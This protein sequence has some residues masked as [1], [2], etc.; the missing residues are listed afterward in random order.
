M[1]PDQHAQDSSSVERIESLFRVSNSKA[2]ASPKE[3]MLEIIL[4]E[5]NN[6]PENM[7]KELI[8][9]RA[10]RCQCCCVAVPKS[11]VS[12]QDILGLSVLL[13]RWVQELEEFEADLESRR[14]AEER[15]IGLLSVM[16]LD[17]I[18]RVTIQ[19]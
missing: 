18:V 9:L 19:V 4:A 2:D 15:H 17:R 8:F 5:H 3:D 11:F 1:N 14:N 6:L 10:M 13:G 16:P 7:R 12:A